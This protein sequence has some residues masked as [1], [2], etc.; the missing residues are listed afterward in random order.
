MESLSYFIQLVDTLKLDLVTIRLWQNQEDSEIEYYD[1]SNIAVSQ[2]QKFVSKGI[3]VPEIEVDLRSALKQL[4]AW[5]DLALEDLSK[6]QRECTA[7]VF[8]RSR[9]SRLD[10]VC[11]MNLDANV[12]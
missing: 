2:L 12:F 11:R 5:S 1:L 7:A 4:P 9:G 6:E 8:V 10:L 3:I